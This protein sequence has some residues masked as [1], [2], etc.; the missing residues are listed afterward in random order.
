MVVN[1]Y[2]F[3]TYYYSHFENGN[4]CISVLNFIDYSDI[5]FMIKI[6]R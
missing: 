6:E 5:I 1:I 3:K 2:S 4:V